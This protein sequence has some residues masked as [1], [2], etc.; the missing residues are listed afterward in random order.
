M[1]DY[2]A[3]IVGQDGHFLSVVELE[4]L[5]DEAARPPSAMRCAIPLSFGAVPA[6]SVYCIMSQT[7]LA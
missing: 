5:C 4:C 6:S 2:K 1:T 3:Y 7:D